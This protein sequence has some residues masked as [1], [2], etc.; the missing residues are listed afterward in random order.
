M[1]G[2]AENRRRIEAVERT[3]TEARDQGTRAL[4]EIAAHTKAC[5]VRQQTIE[6]RLDE[7]G[8][9]QRAA[10]KLLISTLLAV[11]GAILLEVAKNRGFFS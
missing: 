7:L 1:F 3:A 11:L 9:S 5:D 2:G 10:N 4:A 6:R 8:G